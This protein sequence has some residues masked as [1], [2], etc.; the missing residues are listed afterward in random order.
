M[1]VS[2]YAAGRMLKQHKVMYKDWSVVNTHTSARV[3]T[4][5]VCSVLRV[6]VP[7]ALCLIDIRLL[8]MQHSHCCSPALLY[9]SV[10]SGVSS[11]MQCRLTLSARTLC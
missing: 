9:I 8:F 3:Y 2:V 4:V 10:N 5:S 6:L 11:F 1:L 7:R